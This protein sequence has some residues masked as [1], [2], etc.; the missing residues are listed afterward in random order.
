MMENNMSEEKNGR[1]PKEIAEKVRRIV[2]A[3]SAESGFQDRDLIKLR[4]DR[5]LKAVQ[6]G[7]DQIIL[8]EEKNEITNERFHE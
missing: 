8:E 6:E 2:F 1:I 5:M 4:T 3:Y 7:I